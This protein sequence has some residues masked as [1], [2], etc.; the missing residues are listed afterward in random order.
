MILYWL[1][2]LLACV[3]KPNLTPEEAESQGRRLFMDHIAAIGGMA[4]L[5]NH[6]SIRTE[7]TIQYIGDPIAPPFSRS[8]CA[9]TISIVGCESM[10]KGFTSEATMETA[11]GA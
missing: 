8:R 2:M 7:G 4:A 1:L 5:Q 10:T 6:Q 11:H 3:P 9:P